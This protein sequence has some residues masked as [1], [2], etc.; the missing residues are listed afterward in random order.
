MVFETVTT[1]FNKCRTPLKC[2]SIMCCNCLSKT[3]SLTILTDNTT[4][5]TGLESHCF[6][7]V[8]LMIA[9]VGSMPPPLQSRQRRPDHAGQLSSPLTADTTHLVISKRTI[10]FKFLDSLSLVESKEGKSLLGIGYLKL[11]RI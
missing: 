4:T 10:N 3:N 8:L 5:I 1:M 7:Y 11:E 2:D 9:L 6:Q